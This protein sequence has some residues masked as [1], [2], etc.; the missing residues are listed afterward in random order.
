ML[1]LQRGKQTSLI[2]IMTKYKY[3]AIIASIAIQFIIGC[4]ID[5]GPPCIYE[6][7]HYGQT[8]TNFIGR[9]YNYYERA[10][11]YK[12]GQ[13]YSAALSDIDKAIREKP[14][15]NAWAKTY[16]MHFIP[17]YPHRERGIILYLKNESRLVM[18]PK[19]YDKA[20][21]ELEFSISQKQTEK[22]LVWLAKVRKRILELEKQTIQIPEII[23]YIDEQ[24]VNLNTAFQTNNDQVRVSGYVKDEQYV[25]KVQINRNTI[26]RKGSENRINISEKI[27]L[28]HG[29]QEINVSAKNLLGGIYTKKIMVFA[30]LEGPDIALGKRKNILTGFVQDESGVKSLHLIGDAHKENIQFK[31]NGSFKIE[32]SKMIS[33]KI[34]ILALDKWGNSSRLIFFLNSIDPNHK[35]FIASNETSMVSDV[36]LVSLSPPKLSQIVLHGCSAEEH[37]FVDRLSFEGQILSR[38]NQILSWSL[39]NNDALVKQYKISHVSKAN[40]YAI[41]CHLDI[42]PGKNMLSFIAK[43][44]KG[45]KTVKTITVHRKL[46]QIN[47]PQNRYTLKFC[48]FD[49]KNWRNTF[50]LI[51]RETIKHFNHVGDLLDP[52]KKNILNKNFYNKLNQ[53]NRFR[54][55]QMGHEKTDQQMH[56]L[57][58]GDT[59]EEST[60]VEVSVRVISIDSGKLLEDIT[61]YSD[62]KTITGLSILAEDLT[63]KL[64][65]AFPKIKGHIEDTYDNDI[66]VSNDHITK[67]ENITYIHL[68]WPVIVFRSMPERINP[69]TRFSYGYDTEIIAYAK[70]IGKTKLWNQYMARKIAPILHKSYANQDKVVYR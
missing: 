30:D 62:S 61:V 27:H 63:H 18:D 53:L 34:H 38:N 20:R 29:M 67:K 42:E 64:V 24:L 54:V 35:D 55:F 17:Y 2:S 32:I 48:S 21:Q 39:Y 3:I 68:N 52:G 49:D 25:K 1:T 66:L 50:G 23:L 16:G 70:I 65:N 57:L 13:C 58:V 51:Q 31:S 22:A 12:E 5:P 4:K 11:S 43:N 59:C 41:N 9:W 6:M 14:D 8:K 37:V 45:Q 47:Q 44:E 10:I 33:E 7:K 36:D 46:K 69:I 19:A 15:E 28:N 56:P 26:F 60:G 40:A